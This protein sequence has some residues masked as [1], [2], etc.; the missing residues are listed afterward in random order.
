MHFCTAVPFAALLLGSLGHAQWSS[1]PVSNLALGDAAGAQ[2]QSKVIPK[3]GGGS[4]VSWFDSIATGFDVRL[5]SLDLAGNELWGHGGILVADRS[6]S[7]TQDYGLAVDANGFALLAFR[8]DSPNFTDEII[9]ARVSPSGQ[10]AWGVDGLL[11]SGGTQEFVGSPKIA[12]TS[13]GG[14]AVAWTQGSVA[15]LS[16]LDGNG[17]LQWTHQE[18]TGGTGSTFVSDLH[19]S[20]TGLILSLVQQAGGFLSP[21]HLSAIKLDATG[22]NAWPAIVD[23]FDGGSLQIGNFPSFTPDGLGGAVFAWYGTSP[24]QCYAQHVLANGTEAYPHN[25]S[26]VSANTNQI[27]VSPSLDHD[28]IGGNTYVFWEE[29]NT[30]QSSFGLS[31]QKFDNVG[32]PQWGPDGVTAIPLGSTEIRNV[33]T[34]ANAGGPFVFWTESAGIGM[35]VLR[36]RHV[37]GASVT[38]IGPYP[39]ASTPSGKSRPSAVLG[40]SG[41]ALISWSDSRTDGGDILIQNINLDGSLG[42]MPLGNPVCFG[43]GCPCAN[44]DPAAGCANSTGVG[45]SLQALGSSSVAADNLLLVGG[46]LRPNGPALLF[47]GP[48]EVAGGAGQTFGDGLLCVSGSI[49]RLGVKFTDA[50]GNASWGP[51]LITGSG[52]VSPGDNRFLQIWYRDPGAGPCGTGFNTSHGLGLGFGQ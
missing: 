22:A 11:L 33:R 42:N 5:Q 15:K 38:D 10:L 29:Q 12:G 6:L 18:S 50:A 2:V 34:L 28:I 23:V 36:G 13:D 52:W 51:G 35:Q 27:R 46:H 19:A 40:S 3:V 1:D 20:G 24:L 21:R 17:T 8:G 32:A 4:Y 26:P 14:L 48:G 37:D 9:A 39:V 41:H 25:G 44:N 47:A 49:Q 7:S 30:S 43:N 31:G 16:R 45:A